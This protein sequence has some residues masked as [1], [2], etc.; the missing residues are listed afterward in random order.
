MSDAFPSRPTTLTDY[1]AIFRRRLWI[2]LLPLMLVPLLSLALSARQKPLYKASSEIY[3]QRDPT[4]GDPVRYLNTLASVVRDPK[5]AARVVASAGVPG[6]TPGSFLSNSSVTPNPD[7]DLLEVAVT[8]LEAQGA[9]RLVNTY[10]REMTE[11]IT[12]WTKTRPS[13]RRVS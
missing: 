5:L 8:N 10:A 2:V 6:M 13:E 9:V 3:V 11:Y 4:S 1:L 12:E 7:A